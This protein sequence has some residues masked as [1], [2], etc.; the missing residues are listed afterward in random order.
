MTKLALTYGGVDFHELGNVSVREISSAYT[1]EEFPQKETRTVSV[2]IDTWGRESGYNYDA[3]RNALKEA[4]EALRKPNQL[5]TWISPGADSTGGDTQLERP[6]MVVSHDFPEDPNAWGVYQQQLNI[7]FRYELDNAADSGA[8]TVTVVGPNETSPISMGQVHAWKDDYRN[9]FYSEWKNIRQRSTGTVTCAGEIFHGLGETGA[10]A[11]NRLAS[12][13]SDLDEL[14]AKLTEGRYITLTY[15][16]EDNR[17]FDRTVKIESFS[18]DIGQRPLLGSIRWEMTVSYTLFPDEDGYAGA[19]FTSALSKDME[20]GRETLTIS[21]DI[22]AATEALALSKLT[23]LQATVLAAYGAS[24]V[25]Q[26]RNDVTKSWVNANDTQTLNEG[27][28]KTAFMKLSFTCA[29]DFKQVNVQSYALTISDSDDLESG[30]ITRTYAGHV[31]CSSST[32]EEAAYLA[33]VAVARSLGDKKHP[34]RVNKTETRNDR[35]LVNQGSAEFLRLDFSYSYR[36]KG[37]R[38]YLQLATSTSHDTFGESAERVSG[39]VVA[40]SSAVANQ[41]YQT[42]VRALYANRLIRNETFD[43]RKDAVQLADAWYPGSGM[44]EMWQ[45]FDFSLAAYK[46]KPAGTYAIKYGVRVASDYMQLTQSTTIEGVFYGG[47][48]YY[49]AVEAETPNPLK[50]LIKTFTATHGKLTNFQYDYDREAIGT[51]DPTTIGMRFSASYTKAMPVTA[52]IVK[53]SLREEITY[54]GTRNVL[55]D[56]PAGVSVRQACGITPGSRT[57]SGTVTAVNETVALAWVQRQH[58]ATGLLQNWRGTKPADAG[59]YEEPITISTDFE[60]PPLTDGIGRATGVNVQMCA[61]S[62]TFKQIIPNLP[63]PF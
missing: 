56:N 1:P 21:G 10:T 60:F 23:V 36:I 46:E 55:Q 22:T 5:L 4:Q 15:G 33:A 37:S 13:V 20:N 30:L 7:A 29:Y 47:A 50:T 52:M 3:L 8:L 26:T 24:G 48:E 11:D 34:F 14:K 39:F 40:E 27:L 9:N 25:N 51:A 18:A 61:M 16:P 32:S 54:S 44:T 12:C 28:D 63:A 43:E 41:A 19:E 31:I 17:L 49:A 2:R 59:V 62:F 53:C 35:K 57:V 42:N 58:S 6:A 45:R 38:I